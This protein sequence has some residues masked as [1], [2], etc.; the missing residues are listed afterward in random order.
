MTNIKFF[1]KKKF[2][3]RT[4]Q[5]IFQFFEEMKIFSGRTGIFNGTCL[6]VT[7]RNGILNATNARKTK[8]YFFA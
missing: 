6:A 7:L 4:A 2:R 3:T 8:N 1:E 5:T